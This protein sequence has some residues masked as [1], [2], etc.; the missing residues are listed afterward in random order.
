MKYSTIFVAFFLLLGAINALPTQHHSER[1]NTC[2]KQC[3]NHE[4]NLFKE[5]GSTVTLNY[6]TTSEIE[7]QNGQ[8]T[9]VHLKAKVDVATISKCEHQMQLREVQVDGPKE[10]EIMKK[11][12][13]RHS[14]KFSQDNSRIE[15]ICF[16]ENE[17]TWVLNLKKAILSTMQVSV[18]GDQKA[19]QEIL[20]KDV[21][22]YTTTKYE[23]ISSDLIKKTK[24]LSTSSKRS[25][26]VNSFLTGDFGKEKKSTCEIQ[27][28]TK[29]Q[30]LK[31]V[32]CEEINT[33]LPFAQSKASAH[34]A[35]TT[36]LTFEKIQSSQPQSMD[37]Q[38]IRNS[39]IFNKKHFAR[40]QN[41]DKREI[42]EAAE[43]LIEE[44]RSEVEHN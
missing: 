27:L 43:K 25:Q 35:T 5:I 11:Q 18:H 39:L 16:D 4:N 23:Q 28:D 26:S 37:K 15:S 29:R 12:L 33:L 1:T 9:Q 34:V 17:E 14:T 10:A 19:E 3:L 20:E 42:V 13:E 44:I 32:I 2:A 40:R 31:S 6:Q 8:R 41:Q 22:G 36:K 21:L 24:F 30:I 7:L 38:L